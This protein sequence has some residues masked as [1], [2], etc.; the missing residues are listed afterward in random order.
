MKNRTRNHTSFSYYWKEGLKNIF[1][2]GFMSFAAI[3]IILACLLIT[4]S[5]AL[6]SYNIDLKIVD[7]QKQ[8]E[9][10]VFLD[11]NLTLDEA[12][13]VEGKLLAISNV[14]T[15]EFRS[16]DE[17]LTDFRDSLGKNADILEGFDSANNPLANE[18]HITLKD[19]TRTAETVEAIDKLPEVARH[20]VN[21]DT[22]SMLVKVQRVFQIVSG[23]LVIALGLISIFIISNTVK[24]AMFTR[25]DEIAI[26]KMVG[27]TNWF[28]RWP[29]VIEGTVLGL[30]A[31][32][33]AFF[34]QWGVYSKLAGVVG[35]VLPSFDFVPFASIRLLVLGVF[36]IAGVVVGVGGSVLTIRRFM[37][38]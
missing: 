19:V 32:A 24:L 5:V 11:D 8:S 29:F 4:G 21:E 12:R 17:A 7:L 27:A 18:Y 28:I 37:D 22:I 15:A 1:L 26:Q 34:A 31:G 10:V 13:G 20:R 16:A 35:G 30:F 2:H 33:L 3:S 9:I 14:A 25:R 36:L 38:V 23:A 6:I